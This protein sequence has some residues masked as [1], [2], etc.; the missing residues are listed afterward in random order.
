MSKFSKTKVLNYSSKN[1]L[2][3]IIIKEIDKR[4]EKGGSV[5]EQILIA[6]QLDLPAC[7]LIAQRVLEN[8]KN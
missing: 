2:V 5:I 6:K 3:N 8:Q 4:I 1:L 7:H